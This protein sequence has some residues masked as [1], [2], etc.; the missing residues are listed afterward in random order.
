VN[1]IS[2][3]AI[4]VC[5]ARETGLCAHREDREGADEGTTSWWS[6]DMTYENGL[7][8]RNMYPIHR[9]AMEAGTYENGAWVNHRAL[10]ADPAHAS[11]TDQ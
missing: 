2:M 10:A 9:V 8:G 5:W 1:G 7:D 3:G 11:Y 6:P 4:V